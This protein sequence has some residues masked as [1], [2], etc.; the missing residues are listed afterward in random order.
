MH[1]YACICSYDTGANNTHTHYHSHLAQKFNLPRTHAHCH[2]HHIQ[3]FTRAC[4]TPKENNGI[5]SEGDYS[6]EGTNDECWTK[7]ADRHVATLDTFVSLPP[8]N[9]E[10]LIA[11]AAEGPV[12]VAIEADQPAFQHYK[13]GA[14]VIHEYS[15]NH[16]L[17]THESTCNG[18]KGLNSMSSETD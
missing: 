2:L 3:P 14:C 11:A 5:D 1:K 16:L 17:T 18:I 10:A 7:A 4:L 15:H 6:Y 12:S 8:K 13:S 9:E